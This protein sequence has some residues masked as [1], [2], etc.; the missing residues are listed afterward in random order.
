[1]ARR[2]PPGHRRVAVVRG[3][4][5]APGRDGDAPPSR[6]RRADRS[7]RCREATLVNL[8]RRLRLPRRSGTIELDGRRRHP[9]AGPPSRPERARADVPAQPLVPVALSVRE[10]VEVAAIGVGASRA[11]GAPSR[12]PG[13]SACSGLEARA[14]APAS[15]LAARGR[16]AA[17]RCSGARDRAALR[18]H[19]RAGRWSPRG[20]LPDFAAVVRAVRDDHGG[21]RAADR[22]QHGGDHGRVRSHPGP[23]Q[24]RD[25]R[26]GDARLRSAANL[27]VAAAYLGESAV[28]D[29]G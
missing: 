26:V 18:P 27:D 20:R 14:D 4:R 25:A 11:R 6:G 5:G 21:G 8:I 19:G 9:L 7:E 13:S 3:R 10:N 1:M 24:G 28:E 22:P 17:R 29:D 23:D 12:R 16:A 2:V 15:S